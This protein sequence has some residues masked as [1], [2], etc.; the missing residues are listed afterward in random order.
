MLHIEIV[1]EQIE[2]IASALFLK[3]YN[4]FEKSLKNFYLNNVKL[5]DNP[6]LYYYTGAENVKKNIVLCFEDGCTR[7]NEY[8]F[9]DISEKY[10]NYF[11]LKEIVKLDK[12]Y[13]LSKGKFKNLYIDSVNRATESYDFFGTCS[14][15]I[16]MRNKLAHE[17]SNLSLKPDDDIVEILDDENINSI[18]N[19]HFT[20]FDLTKMNNSTKA[21]LSNSVFVD[22]VCEKIKSLSQINNSSR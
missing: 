18:Y 21:I 2:A 7:F 12:L 14:K 8:K 15:L 20:N 4:L 22:K 16:S 10:I 9:K 3:K 5:N 19:E 11:T 1:E 17:S 13:D 6:I